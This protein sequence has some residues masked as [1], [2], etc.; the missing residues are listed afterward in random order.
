VE[1]YPQVAGAEL[2]VLGDC[3]DAARRGN[4][5]VWNGAVQSF[6]VAVGCSTVAG[7]SLKRG[8]T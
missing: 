7:L 2:V 1:W 4:A 8:G 5:A 3:Y 6:C